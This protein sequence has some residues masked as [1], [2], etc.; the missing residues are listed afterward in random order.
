VIS[1]NGEG[2]EFFSKLEKKYARFFEKVH[3]TC[4]IRFPKEKGLPVGASEALAA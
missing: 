3:R 2:Q 4:T 1:A